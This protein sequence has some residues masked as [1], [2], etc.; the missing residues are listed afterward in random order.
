MTK[1]LRDRISYL[2]DEE[3]R[4]RGLVDEAHRH[5]DLLDKER[6]SREEC[7]C[8]RASGGYT[9]WRRYA[10]YAPPTDEYVDFNVSAKNRAF[11]D[12]FVQ[13]KAWQEIFNSITTEAYVGPIDFCELLY[14][15]DTRGVLCLTILESFYRHLDTLYLPHFGEKCAIFFDTDSIE[16]WKELCTHLVNELKPSTTK[17]NVVFFDEFPVIF[18]RINGSLVLHF[19]DFNE[20]NVE[21]VLPI[22]YFSRQPRSYEDRIAF[23]SG[24]VTTEK[25]QGFS[26]KLINKSLCCST[27]KEKIRTRNGEQRGAHLQL[28]SIS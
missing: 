3:H 20:V 8:L 12:N 26:E 23:T 9:V 10:I 13:T 25:C 24:V 2:L 6:W 5:R 11:V 28:H 14:Y 17:Q 19:K 22:H 15:R 1:E 7:A 16:N 21:Q 18:L 27:L 4:L